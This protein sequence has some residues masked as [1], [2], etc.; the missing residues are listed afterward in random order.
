M[1]PS[2]ICPNI[3]SDFRVSCRFF[4]AYKTEDRNFLNYN[5]RVFYV[6]RALERITTYLQF[7]FI[8][9]IFKVV[10]AQQFV[11]L[12]SSGRGFKARSHI[13]IYFPVI[14]GLSS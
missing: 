9:Q 10:M 8:G 5:M 4:S 11:L 12:N 14:I 1:E 3:T 6:L 7:S 2:Y 13:I